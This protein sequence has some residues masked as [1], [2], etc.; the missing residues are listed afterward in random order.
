MLG[1]NTDPYQHAEA[2]L[3]VSRSILE[4]LSRYNHPVVIITK[5][6]LIERDIDL[7][8][9][10]AQRKLAKVAV[11]LTTLSTDLKRS[12]E[13]RTSS[14]QA[15]L[16]II[17]HFSEAGVPVRVMA[18]PI[19]PMINDMELERILGMAATAGAR[20]ASYVLIRLPYEIKDLFREWLAT[21]YPDRAEH[22]M[23][24]IQQMRGGKDYDATFGKRMRGEGEYAN[25]LNQRFD[26]ACRRYHLNMFPT[27]TLDTT[28]FQRP[29]K[30][31][32]ATNQMDLWG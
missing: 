32:P 5:S 29:V 18:A 20:H 3:K 27:E 8:A 9:D 26:I 25:L 30:S 17:R 13:P 10:M 15:R 4:T 31:K 14:P 28:H 6:S 19:I 7:I 16:R 22:V 2:K 24:L 23:S 12:L 1:A 21:H 11:S